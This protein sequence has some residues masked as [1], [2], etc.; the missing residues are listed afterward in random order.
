M[1]RLNFRKGETGN[2]IVGEEKLLDYQSEMIPQY[3][4]DDKTGEKEVSSS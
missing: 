3:Y 1:L 4:S 2:L